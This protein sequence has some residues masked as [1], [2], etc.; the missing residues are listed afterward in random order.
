MKNIKRKQ[1]GITLIALVI[2]IL[3]L[4]ILATVTIN[5]AF[6][7]NGLIKQAEYAKDLSSNTT[8]SEFDGMNSLFDEYANMM[9]E[10][11]NVPTGPSTVEEVKPDTEEDIKY[12]DKTTEL[13]DDSGDSV[14][15]PGGFGVTEDSS[16]DA[17]NG[18]VIQDRNGNEFVWIPVPD[19]TTMY[20]ET[21]GIA[22][23]GSS[24]GVTTTT[25]VYSKLRIRSEDLTIYSNGIPG[26]TNTTREPD[27]LPNTIHG[28]ASTTSGR[29][30]NQLKNV[31][32]ITGATNAEVLNNFA[33]SIVDE[34][35]A[36]YNSI[37][38]YKGFYIGRYELTGSVDQPTVKQGATL[39][40]VDWYNLK[41]ACTNVV[42]T[43]FAQTTMAYGSQWD[44]VM[45]WLKNNVF[46]NDT[47]KVDVDSSSWGNYKNINVYNSEGTEIIKKSG[48]NIKLETGITTY[49]M[50][51][52]I[53]DLAGNCYEW[54]QEV[55]SVAD[56]VGRGGFCDHAGADG[57][58]S[59]RHNSYSYNSSS[60]YSSRPTL[61]I[62]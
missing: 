54:T 15:V 55:L 11:D 24:V 21:E 59:D 30:I 31:L 39:T 9:S 13:E 16:I 27:I 6:G 56:R 19:Y 45:S 50:K 38:K 49:T 42:S 57:P 52:N 14:W 12:F 5:V 28:D 4:I 58:A 47:D 2:T 36:T 8:E 20:I 10:D 51:N 40:N 35:T 1:L 48:T 32:S 22:L 53:Y 29:G 23:S 37:R 26:N 17:D 33:Q 3:I 41:K 60:S 43:E 62:K 61:Y 44:E 34:Y 7:D 25:D 46:K 18:I